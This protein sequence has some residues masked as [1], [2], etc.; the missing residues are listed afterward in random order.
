M[1]ILTTITQR[2]EIRTPTQL[3]AE[4]FRLMDLVLL[5]GVGQAQAMVIVVIARV[6]TAGTGGTKGTDVEKNMGW[7]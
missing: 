6:V 1:A 2:A 5:T 4:R 7:L 3:N